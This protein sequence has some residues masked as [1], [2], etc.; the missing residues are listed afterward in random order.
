MSLSQRE[1]A[2]RT[3]CDG[4][5]RCLV[6]TTALGAGVNLP[7]T[8]VVVR[9]NTFPGEG[10][11]RLG[12]DELLQMM[13][14][15]GRGDTPGT[16][17]VLTQP[18][19]GWGAEELAV[20]LRLESLPPLTSAFAASDQG[21]AARPHGVVPTAVRPVMSFLS[22][23]GSGG[24]DASQVQTFFLRSLGGRHMASQCRTATD[25]LTRQDVLLAYA[26]E[27]K[28]FHLTVLGVE[29]AR[30]VLP[31]A[32]AAGLGQLLR[33]LLEAFPDEQVLSRWGL[34]DS[35]VLVELLSDHPVKLRRYAAGLADQ[36]HGWIEASSEKSVLYAEWLRGKPG[37]SRADE[38]MGSLGVPTAN[39]GRGQDRAEWCRQQGVLAVHRALVLFERGRGVAV[40]DL[41]RRW[42]IPDL[43]GIEERWRDREVWLLAG[44]ARLLDLRCFY[45]HLLETCAAT[46]DR[47]HRVKRLLQRMRA[48]AFELIEHLTYCSPLG[49][50]LRS[51]RSVSGGAGRKVGITSIRKLEEA[52][53]TTIKQLGAMTSDELVGLGL[54]PVFARQVQAYVARRLRA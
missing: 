28:R 4:Q 3:F 43:E 50:M 13:G 37:S 44:L 18:G 46:P 47:V 31:P 40:D 41:V 22:R 27:Q 2:R 35:L 38:V 23:V 1:Q 12:V 6:T 48:Q 20:A 19:S 32:F 51:L 8:Y 34:L 52:G 11:G 5:S 21:R 7:A 42:E 29:T 10:G 15:A 33:D 14:R 30:G 9:D 54:Q 24:A 26:D 36:V 25:W 53:V 45:H 39:G 17:T 16:A 49:P